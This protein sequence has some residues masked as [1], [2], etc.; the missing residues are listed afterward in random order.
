[1]LSVVWYA[2]FLYQTVK[3]AVLCFICS[4]F[5]LDRDGVINQYITT[6]LLLQE[7]EECAGGLGSG[8]EEVPLCHADALERVLQIIPMLHSTSE[9]TDSLCA[10]LFKVRAGA[11]F[12]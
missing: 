3:K 2:S 10:A 8:Q 9:L 12:P 11:C 5:G 4:T 1:M 7:D 6:L